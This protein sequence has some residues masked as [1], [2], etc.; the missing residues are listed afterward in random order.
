MTATTPN[1]TPS[2]MRAAALRLARRG[3]R[4]FPL[5]PDTGNPA[6]ERWPELATTDPAVIANWW[7]TLWP[8]AN[9][10]VET[11]GLLVVDVDVKNGKPGPESLDMLRLEHGDLPATYT[12]RTPSGGQHLVM[13]A[14]AG[15]DLR[16][17]A[18]KLGPGLDVR[19]WHGFIVGAGST[20]AGKPYTADDPDA[21]I[22]NAP[23]WLVELCR[24][25]GPSAT[26][27]RQRGEPAAELDTP[28]SIRRVTEYLSN[29]AE[30]AIEGAGGDGTAYRTACRVRDL[31]ASES[32]A[33]ALML[34][35]WNERCAPPWDP[36]DLAVKV[37][38]AYA[39]AENR[40]ASATAAADFAG[41]PIPAPPAR[42]AGGEPDI[43]ALPAMPQRPPLY[44]TM[45]R[46]VH[47]RFDQRALVQE[48]LDHT[49]MSV[50]YGASNS[51]K[52]FYAMGLGWSVA[53]GRDFLGRPVEQRGVVYV[54]AEAGRSAEKRIAALRKHSG[55]ADPPFALVPCAV[56]LLRPNGDTRAL[57]DL[58]GQAQAAM[59][60]PVGLVI[61]DTLSRA[62]AGG[63]ENAPDD[64]GAL[65][66]H[67]DQIRVATGAH[68]L[69]V[70]HSG[71]NQAAGA[72]GHS[73][74]RAA[75][76]T[77]IEIHERVI[78]VTK[79]RD[80]DYGPGQRFGLHVVEVGAGPDGRL[81]SSCVVVD[82]GP[83]EVAVGL[84]GE[85]QA[86]YDALAAMLV[87]E[88]RNIASKADWLVAGAR[89]FPI[90][91]L[92]SYFAVE[93]QDELSGKVLP[94]NL[95]IARLRKT[96]LEK[97]VE[98]LADNMAEKGVWSK[99]KR[100]Q[101]LI[102]LPGDLSATCRQVSA[103]NLSD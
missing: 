58:I 6:I 18:S 52:T 75:T 96:A 32:Q 24:A 47:P 14:P 40:A 36:D 63:N 79:Q 56:D 31:G 62:L 83:A 43:F 7:G 23:Q 29:F 53:T 26:T 1:P 39:Y 41:A 10:G 48:L 78:R 64:M 4:V 11:T 55:I 22:A 46:D 67:L 82:G 81:A 72:R 38:N 70:H 86:L 45:A 19:S 16:N 85:E 91:A 20:K 98:R 59:G 77:E 13:R 5:I 92:T 80:M 37:R 87:G 42:P 44:F 103:D 2:P 60:R 9:V 93:N 94:A 74:L 73:L 28:A 57:I 30:P 3:F 90:D 71:K 97:R 99:G 17:S 76:D 69:V 12:Q 68:V 61:I 21:P 102:N 50:V 65:V 88:G 95:E 66:R 15:V 84:T 27:E 51:G 35:R 49:A 33:L 89:A 54:A 34:E 8:D 101:Y 100:D 25:S